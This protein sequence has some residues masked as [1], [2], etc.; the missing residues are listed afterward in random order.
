VLLA[1]DGAEVARLDLG[2][3]AG[4]GA[5]ARPGGSERVYLVP[6]SVAE[7]IPASAEAVEG[8]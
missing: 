1:A 4:E 6:R 5:L 2:R 7:L 3:E 8:R